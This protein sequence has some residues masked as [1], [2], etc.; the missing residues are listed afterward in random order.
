MQTQPGQNGQKFLLEEEG[1][2][3]WAL[4]LRDRNHPRFTRFYSHAEM[5]AY[6]QGAFAEVGETV[7]GDW[8]DD[9]Q[10]FFEEVWNGIKSAAIA[11]EHWIV[12][13]VNKVVSFIAKVGEEIVQLANLVI[14]GLKGLRRSSALFKVSLRRSQ[15]LLR[16]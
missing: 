1:V 3:G 11:V 9:V 13:T 14:K 15:L 7:L 8:W 10:N 6:K 12:D 16:R 5:D 4:D 2:V